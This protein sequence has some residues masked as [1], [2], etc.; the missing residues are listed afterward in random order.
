[1][2]SIEPVNF[3]W[4]P[5]NQYILDW[6]ENFTTQTKREC[7]FYNKSYWI[8]TLDVKV[9]ALWIEFKTMWGNSAAFRG[10]NKFWFTMESELNGNI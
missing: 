4:L 8:Q 6:Y 7:R 3:D 5:K 2:N 9:T 10:C 1:M